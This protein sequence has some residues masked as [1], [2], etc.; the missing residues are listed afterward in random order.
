MKKLFKCSVCGY[1]HEGDSVPEECPK[2]HV[3]AEKFEELAKEAADKIYSSDKTNGIHIEIITLAEKI[4]KI[5]QKGIDD[6]LDPKCVAAF[7]QA[8]DEAWVIK[9]RCK[10]ELAGHMNAGKW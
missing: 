5:S 6:N 9:Q 7:T 3:G 1:V 4:I 2:C 8:K 10:T